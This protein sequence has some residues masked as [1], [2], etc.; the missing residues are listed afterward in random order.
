VTARRKRRIALRSGDWLTV[1]LRPRIGCVIRRE[2]KG[3]G[4]SIVVPLGEMFKLAS[5]L[6]ELRRRRR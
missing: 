1:E 3:L 2:T 5:A 4:P 6:L